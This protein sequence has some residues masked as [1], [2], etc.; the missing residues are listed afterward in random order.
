MEFADVKKWIIFFF[1]ILIAIIVADALSNLIMNYSGLQGWENFVVSFIL[2]AVFF[3]AIL[4]VLEKVGGIEF[5]GFER[6]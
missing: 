3:F 6:D 5:F 1:G 4:Y 2:Y